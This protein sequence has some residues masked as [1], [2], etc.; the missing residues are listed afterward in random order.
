[1]ECFRHMPELRAQLGALRPAS[2]G[3][4]QLVKR[5]VSL[6][7][8]FRDAL[9]LVDHAGRSIPP[10][11]FV[12]VLRSEFEQFRQQSDH[13]GYMQQDAE[14]FYN[15]LTQSLNS[16]LDTMGPRGAAFKESFLNI[17]MEDVLTCNE[18]P[19]EPP[20]VKHE[21]VNR[22]VCNIQG[23][24]GS[25]IVINHLHE[26]L[27]LSLEGVVDKT[28]PILGRNA[29]WSKRSKIAK[30]PQYICIQF[31]RFFWKATPESRDHQ[32][33]KCKILRPVSFLEVRACQT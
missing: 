10:S 17:K 23:G 28:S 25:S 33:V 18:S 5:A 30:L 27:K 6:A 1:M 8:T 31:M 19:D 14:E 22:L 11:M 20:S 9:N 13:G 3:E 15:I 24:V 7:S 32:G 12:G 2:S 16:A 26:G 21:F 29:E 4:N